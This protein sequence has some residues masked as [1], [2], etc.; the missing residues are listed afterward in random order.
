MVV[1]MVERHIANRT[2]ARDLKMPEEH[3]IG[4]LRN[5]KMIHIFP[6][7][8]KTLAFQRNEQRESVFFFFFPHSYKNDS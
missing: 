2:R 1:A 7:R 6:H 4:R 3:R 8:H 5:R